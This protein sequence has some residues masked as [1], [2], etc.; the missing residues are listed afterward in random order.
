MSGDVCKHGQLERQCDRCESAA[1][2]AELTAAL[3]EA[4]QKPPPLSLRRMETLSNALTKIIMRLHFLEE[5]LKWGDE[6]RR[7]TC[8][9]LTAAGVH[10]V[11]PTGIEKAAHR[12]KRG[13]RPVV[14]AYFGAPLQRYADLFV[15]G[16]QTVPVRGSSKAAGPLFAKPGRAS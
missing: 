10:L 6:E 8:E 12:L 14:R 13:A 7:R 5:P 11:T 15:L 1:E 2:I 16:I 3:R 9:L 4:K